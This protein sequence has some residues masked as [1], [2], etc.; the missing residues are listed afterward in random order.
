MTNLSVN[1]LISHVCFC[2][3]V[4]EKTNTFRLPGPDGDEKKE[5]PDFLSHQS[6]HHHLLLS[7]GRVPDNLCFRPP[8]S[9]ILIQPLMNIILI[10]LLACLM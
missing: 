10:D 7:S 3:W 4:V 8:E 2:L 9:L 5:S 6:H 1:P